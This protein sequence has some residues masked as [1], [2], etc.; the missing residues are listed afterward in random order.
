MGTMK[1]SIPKLHS[2]K[3]KNH[4]NVEILD[5]AT[6]NNR[7]PQGVLVAALN[8]RMSEV[9]VLGHFGEDEL[10]FSSS[11]SDIG[12]ILYLLEMAKIRVLGNSN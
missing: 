9:V 7:C 4:Y 5:V 10:Y 8:K 3:M 1:V 6:T 11:Q 2:L 12:S